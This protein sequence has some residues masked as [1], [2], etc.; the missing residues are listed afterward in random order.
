MEKLRG[1]SNTGLEGSP[2]PCL[3]SP[4]S[5]QSPAL[6]PADDSDFQVFRETTIKNAINLFGTE[7]A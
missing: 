3:A 4:S 5:L 6:F 1:N 2:I 7:H